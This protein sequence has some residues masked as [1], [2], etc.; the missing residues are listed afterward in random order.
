[1]FLIRQTTGQFSTWPY[2]IL[3]ELR[4]RKKINV[5]W[6]YLYLVSSLVLSSQTITVFTDGFFLSVHELMHWPK[7][8]RILSLQYWFMSYRDS[9]LNSLQFYTEEHYSKLFAHAV[10][11]VYCPETPPLWDAFFFLNTHLCNRPLVN[12]PKWVSWSSTRCLLTLHNI[13]SRLLPLSQFFWDVLLASNSKQ[14]Y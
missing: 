2:S 3:N 8:P 7:A 5:P 13:S 11:Y 6:S 4:P 10:F 12:K 1:M 14:A 9:S